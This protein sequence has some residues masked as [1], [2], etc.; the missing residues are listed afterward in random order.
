MILRGVNVTELM[1]AAGLERATYYYI[2]KKGGTSPRT[3]KAIA[4]T[5]N[6]DPP[7][8]F[9]RAGE[10]AASWQ[11]DRLMNGRNKYWREARWDKNQPARLA[12]IKEKRSKSM[13]KVVQ[14]TFQQIPY[15]KLR[16]RFHSCGFRIRRLQMQSASEL[17]Q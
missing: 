9:E 4:D 6:V 14:G 12:H 16:G 1:Q 3:L 5:L 15:W 8:A 17:T 13:M 10:G 7:R 11:G 2:K